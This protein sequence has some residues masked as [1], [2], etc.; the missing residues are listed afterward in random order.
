[1]IRSIYYGFGWR[2]IEAILPVRWVPGRK[3]LHLKV[4]RSAADGD[5]VISTVSILGVESSGGQ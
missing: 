4:L 5:P 3:E 2:S 1:M